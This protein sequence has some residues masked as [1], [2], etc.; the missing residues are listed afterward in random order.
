[1]SQKWVKKMTQKNDS[2]MTQKMT[3]KWLKKNKSKNESLLETSN[4]TGIVFLFA[5]L[6]DIVSRV[7]FGSWGQSQVVSFILYACGSENMGSIPTNINFLIAR[8]Y[9]LV[10][11]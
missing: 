2:K 3:Q 7:P 9:F 11:K 6:A 8:N 10:K 5:I 4:P 1:M